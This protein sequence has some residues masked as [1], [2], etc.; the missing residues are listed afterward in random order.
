M[1]LRTLSAAALGVALSALSAE[2]AAAQASL[3]EAIK[4]RNHQGVRMLLER[5]ANANGREADGTT[6]LHWAV[7]VDDL[8]S[9]Q[10]LLRAGAA[11]NVANRYGAIVRQD[12][13][14]Y[15]MVAGNPAAPYAV[16][17]EGLKRRGFTEDQIRA[18]RDAYRIL[19]RSGLRLS[20]AMARLEPIAAER[21]E[22][23]A[24]V[25]F[26]QAITRSIVR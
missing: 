21:T 13:P 15:V 2:P 20:E 23:R 19:Y 8:E 7:R 17:A 10:L 1:N 6:P 24:F 11:V 18:I 14:P 3:T 22:I 12:V 9:V 26:I 5:R 16:N 4:G 25:D